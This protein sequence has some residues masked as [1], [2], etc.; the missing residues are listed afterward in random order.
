MIT[1]LGIA[2]IWCLDQEETK[3]FFTEQL[4]FECRTDITMGEGGMRWV[5]IGPPEQPELQLALMVP[6]PP[7]MDPESA[8]HMKAL[9]AKGVLGAGVFNTEDC[10]ATYREYKARGVEFVQEPQKRPYGVE[11]IFRDNSGNWY[12]LTQAFHQLDESASWCTDGSA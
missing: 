9:I 7:S 5:T 11:A 4:G 12:S 1:G 8:A 2:T 3:K 6:G 10:E